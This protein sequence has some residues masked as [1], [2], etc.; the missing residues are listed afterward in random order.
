MGKNGAK[1]GYIGYSGGEKTY[2]LTV[3]KFKKEHA[4]INEKTKYHHPTQKPV[5]LIRY[6]IRTYTNP[7]DLVLDNCMGSGSTA[8]AALREGRNFIGFE[9]DEHYY[10]MCLDRIADEENYIEEKKKEPKPN[11]P[12]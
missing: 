1:E 7:G 6:L 10:K 5:D 11:P 2:P 3:L 12:F 4:F 8:I 9:L